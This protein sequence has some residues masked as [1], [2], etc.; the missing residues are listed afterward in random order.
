MNEG[1]FAVA[2]SGPEARDFQPDPV[3]AAAGRYI[4]GPAAGAAPVAVGHLL[5]K[6]QCSQV[7]AFSGEDPEAAGARAIEIAF[8]VDLN[9]IGQAILC[10]RRRVKEHLGVAP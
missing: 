8:L 6:L 9:T 10:I 7:L 1:S 5:R 4:E 3:N 2:A